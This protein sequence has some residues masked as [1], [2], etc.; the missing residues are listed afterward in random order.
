MLLLPII[1]IIN[2][3]TTGGKPIRTLKIN[4]IEFLNGKFDKAKKDPI[5]TPANTARITDI[6]ET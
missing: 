6:K 5:K 4:M 2:P 1:Y 3:A